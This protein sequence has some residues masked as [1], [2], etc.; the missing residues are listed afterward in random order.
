M[1]YCHYTLLHLHHLNETSF[2]AD[3]SL[4]ESLSVL[5]ELEEATDTVLGRR[6]WPFTDVAV[7]VAGLMLLFASTFSLP[8]TEDP[9]LLLVFMVTSEVVLLLVLLVAEL[10]DTVLGKEW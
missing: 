7:V 9:V 1:Y 5:A 6:I 2:S 4:S 10:E 8:A 3:V